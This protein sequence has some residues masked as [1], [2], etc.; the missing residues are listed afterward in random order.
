MDK[1]LAKYLEF[2]VAYYE[3]FSTREDK[4]WGLL[5]HNESQPSYYDANHAHI[6]EIPKDP[7]AVINEVKEFY[8]SKQL[9]PRFY[10]YNWLNQAKLQSA[11]KNNN[12]QSE[13][14]VSPFQIWTGNIHEPKH[15]E[16]I[17][18]EKVTEDNYAEALE[19]ECSI[20][21]FGGKEVR[22]KA[23]PEDFRNP[24]MTFYLLR[25]HGVACSVASIFEHNGQ[26]RVESVATL[27]EYRGKGLIGSLISHVQA[28]AVAKGLEKFWIIPINEKI[29]KVYAKYEF[30]TVGK[31]IT[32]HA[33]LS[34]KSITELQG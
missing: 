24:S 34:G 10:I 6:S 13:E 22:E 28:K 23:F 27:K 33:F 19:I 29:E 25:Y 1:I 32:G 15:K 17:T 20:E 31:F 7:Q 4:P 14:I 2:D 16:G 5:F 11:L 8:E 18:C 9:T 26:G 12:F 21:E 30:E 3:S